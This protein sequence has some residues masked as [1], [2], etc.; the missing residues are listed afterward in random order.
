MIFENIR[1]AV[2]SLTKG[3]ESERQEAATVLIAIGEDFDKIKSSCDPSE[4][5]SDIRQ[6]IA[7]LSISDV[8]AVTE[9]YLQVENIEGQYDL[10]RVC[11]H[12][13]EW[14]LKNGDNFG[15]DVYSFRVDLDDSGTRSEFSV[16]RAGDHWSEV[17]RYYRP[18]TGG[19]MVHT[20]RAVNGVVS[21]WGKFVDDLL[22]AG[23]TVGADG[24]DD[25]NVFADRLEVAF[26]LHTLAASEA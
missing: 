24:G 17:R 23:G 13:S 18:A 12:V 20:I 7:N 8:V 2:E 22:V 14:L 19:E 10:T 5:A 3:N 4:Y 6:E 21:E 15:D 26:D 1:L 25:I 11:N 16:K 9:L